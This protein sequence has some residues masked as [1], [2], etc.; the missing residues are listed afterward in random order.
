M[1]GN[2]LTD[3]NWASELADTVERV[4]S[5]V[6][7]KTTNNVVLAARGVVFGLLAAILG[8]TALVLLL[9]TSSRALQALLDIWLPHERSVY[10]SY[11]IIGGICCL[12]GLFLMRKRHSGG[13]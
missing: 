9:L 3:P 6:R 11:L 4:V 5:T 12:G 8:V 1:P 13:A 2:P 10:L 7:D